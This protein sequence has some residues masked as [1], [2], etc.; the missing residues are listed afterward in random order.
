MN[1]H[2][3]QHQGKLFKCPIENC[4]S[5]FAYQGNVKRHLEE[6]HSEGCPSTSVEGQ[7]QHVCQEPGCGKA[8][9]Y[10][11]RLRKHEYSHGRLYFSILSLLGSTVYLFSFSMLLLNVI[12]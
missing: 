6:C 1:R 7:K 4:K 9:Q 12:K 8:F 2:L 3:L 10:A 11:S 5:E